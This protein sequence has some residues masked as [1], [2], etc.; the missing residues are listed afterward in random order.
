[1]GSGGFEGVRGSGGGAGWR[2]RQCDLCARRYQRPLHLAVSEPLQKN[3]KLWAPFDRHL[4]ENGTTNACLGGL[5]TRHAEAG[6]GH[7]KQSGPN[8]SRCLEKRPTQHQPPPPPSPLP[9]RLLLLHQEM[10]GKKQ[11]R[12]KRKEKKKQGK[13]EIPH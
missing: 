7:T 5:G 13:Q 1:M 11:K 9:H 4:Y 12:K 3:N 8:R 2:G 10:R 6:G